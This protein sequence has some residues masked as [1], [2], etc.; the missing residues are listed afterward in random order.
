M[1]PAHRATRLIYIPLVL[2]GWLRYL[3]GVDR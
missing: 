3:E 1:L 2:A